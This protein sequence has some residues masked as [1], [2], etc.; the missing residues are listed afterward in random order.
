M[1]PARKPLVDQVF[2]WLAVAVERNDIVRCR[3]FWRSI[4]A[5]Y[6]DLVIARMP[7]YRKRLGEILAGMKQTKAVM[8]IRKELGL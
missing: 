8:A 5:L 6:D 1:I 3:Q 4:D 7:E 2:R